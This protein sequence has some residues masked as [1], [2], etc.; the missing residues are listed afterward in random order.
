M[1]CEKIRQMVAKL[2]LEEKAALTS[3]KDNWYTKSIE[4]CGGNGRTDRLRCR[5]RQIV[6]RR[7]GCMLHA[8]DLP[9]NE[10][11]GKSNRRRKDGILDR[12]LPKEKKEQ[13]KQLLIELDSGSRRRQ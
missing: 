4:R 6:R 10:N 3:G 1:E 12:F 2:T 11:C 7:S 13:L 8:F 9:C 5:G